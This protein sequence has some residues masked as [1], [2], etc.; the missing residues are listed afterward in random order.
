MCTPVRGLFFKVKRAACGPYDALP[1]SMLLPC[2]PR[3]LISGFAASSNPLGRATAR[4]LR[5]T[6]CS[7]APW[8]HA[9]CTGAP[10]RQRRSCVRSVNLLTS[11]RICSVLSV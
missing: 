3:P 10:H 8:R 6:R 4:R 11:S 1:A 2:S 5:H 9:D 7:S